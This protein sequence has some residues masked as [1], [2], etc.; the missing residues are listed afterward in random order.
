MSRGLPGDIP[1]LFVFLV[2][3]FRLK[4]PICMKKVFS[5]AE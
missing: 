5:A 4:C 1:S 2:F 3:S